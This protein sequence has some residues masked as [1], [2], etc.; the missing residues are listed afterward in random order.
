MSHLLASKPWRTRLTYAAMSLLVVWH[1][2]AMLVGPAPESVMTLA[3]RKI[4]HPYITLFRMDNKWGYFAP[5]VPRGMQFRYIVEDAAGQRHTFIPDDT[6]SR[7]QPNAIWV[8]DRYK[9]VM[10]FPDQYGDAAVASLCRD[11]AALKPVAITLVEV[12]QKDFTPLDRRSGKHPLDPE[13]VDVN[14][15]KPIPCPDK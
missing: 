11:H 8:K 10:A 6:L 3:A 4:F 7:F 15:L 12:E 5:E 2:L 14:A 9:T 1:T 13:F